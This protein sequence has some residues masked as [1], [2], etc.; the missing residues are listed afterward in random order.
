MEHIHGM[1][2]NHSS[3]G[4]NDPEALL[5]N[6]RVCDTGHRALVGTDSTMTQGPGR[7]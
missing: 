7:D 4:V 1:G 5:T 6:Q 3:I 2:S